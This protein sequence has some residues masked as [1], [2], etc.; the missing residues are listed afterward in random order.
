M[1]ITMTTRTRL[2][3]MILYMIGLRFGFGIIFNWMFLLITDSHP[4]IKAIKLLLIYFLPL[5][6]PLTFSSPFSSSIPS[7]HLLF[8]YL[9]ITVR[10]ACLSA[11]NSQKLNRRLQQHISSPSSA[12][13]TTLPPAR[14]S[15]VRRRRPSG[16]FW[17]CRSIPPCRPP[18]LR[19]CF[20]VPAAA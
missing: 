18:C 4:L 3:T 5:S 8:D 2:M 6:L 17:L 20:V 15:R 13:R 11:S 7:P 12:P 19:R 9:P 14:G 16:A 10:L 1:L